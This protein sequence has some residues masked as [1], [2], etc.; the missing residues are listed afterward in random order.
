MNRLL[1]SVIANLSPFEKLHNKKPSLHHLG[2]F[3]CPCLAMK[4]PESDKLKSRSTACVLMGYAETQKGYVLYDLSNKVLFV[5]RDVVFQ[6]V[7]FPF[8]LKMSQFLYLLIMA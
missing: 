5:N 8:K 1:S 3:R 4:V 7:V 2:V 6:E